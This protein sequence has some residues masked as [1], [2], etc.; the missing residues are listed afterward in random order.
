METFQNGLGGFKVGR[1]V[2]SFRSPK[3]CPA[4]ESPGKPSAAILKGIDIRMA[5]CPWMHVGF[6]ICSLASALAAQQPK[7]SAAPSFEVVSIR[8]AELGENSKLRS[9]SQGRAGFFPSFHRP[10]TMSRCAS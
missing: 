2:V 4:L 3:Q 5:L 6:A 10:K 7:A 9:G 8:P 1:E